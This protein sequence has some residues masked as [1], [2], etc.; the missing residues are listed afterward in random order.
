MKVLTAPPV[1][2]WLDILTVLA[3]CCDALTD[4]P[5]SGVEADVGCNAIRRLIPLFTITYL[6]FP[7]D[8]T[9]GHLSCTGVPVLAWG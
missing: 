5:A 9:L 8:I 2:A 6:T 1:N 7:R 3:F 4:I